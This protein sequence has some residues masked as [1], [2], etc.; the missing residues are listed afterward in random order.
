MLTKSMAME[1]GPY[2]VGTGA[3]GC[4]G[5]RPKKARRVGVRWVVGGKVGAGGSE[6]GSGASRSE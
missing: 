6:R 4:Q 1:L 2:K 5:P 3:L